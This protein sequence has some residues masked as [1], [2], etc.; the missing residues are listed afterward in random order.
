MVIRGAFNRGAAYEG[1]G[2]PREPQ[3]QYR[4]PKLGTAGAASLRPCGG[5]ESVVA[6]KKRSRREGHPDGGWTFRGGGRQPRRLS[7]LPSSL[8]RAP[9]WP[10]HMEAEGLEA[11]IIESVQASALE[12]KAVCREVENGT[13]GHTG[14]TWEGAP[15]SPPALYGVQALPWCGL[16]EWG[17]QGGEPA[18]LCRRESG[19]LSS[20]PLGSLLAFLSSQ[21]EG[22][23]QGF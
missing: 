9:L 22:C 2:R 7:S 11:Q 10:N 14:D 1:V 23:S 17:G 13:S 4:T 20:A 3:G 18:T 6:G 15:G 19:R 12:Q 16:G 21:V 8:A 5:G